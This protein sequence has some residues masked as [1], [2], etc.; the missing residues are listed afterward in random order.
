[1]SPDLI[2]YDTN[3]ELVPKL[4]SPMETLRAG[5]AV[6]VLRCTDRGEVGMMVT[7]FDENNFGPLDTFEFALSFLCGR[8]GDTAL[9]CLQ[10]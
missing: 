1:M 7:D 6:M 8:M 3:E 10:F 5:T 2:P 9:G 4:C